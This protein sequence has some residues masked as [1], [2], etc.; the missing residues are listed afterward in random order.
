MRMMDIKTFS[1]ERWWCIGL[2]NDGVKN[3]ETRV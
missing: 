2:G 1:R 3:K